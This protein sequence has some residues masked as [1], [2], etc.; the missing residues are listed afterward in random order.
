MRTNLSIATRL[1]RPPVREQGVARDFSC[2]IKDVIKC[3]VNGV[4]GRVN[5]RVVAGARAMDKRRM[6]NLTA[7]YTKLTWSCG[8]F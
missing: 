2:V 5:N 4:M 6:V 7:N 1:L 3:V 8:S